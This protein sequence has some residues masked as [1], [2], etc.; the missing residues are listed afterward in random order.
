MSIEAMLQELAERIEEDEDDDECRDED[1]E[2]VLR[3]KR[4][5]VSLK[6]RIAALEQAARAVLNGR[7]PAVSAEFEGS[8][9]RHSRVSDSL[10]DKLAH[11]LDGG[12]ADSVSEFEDA[13]D[14]EAGSKFRAAERKEASCV[15]VGFSQSSASSSPSSSSARIPSP[16]GSTGA[17]GQQPSV[18]AIDSTLREAATNAYD[19]WTSGLTEELTT[20]MAALRDVLDGARA[21][22]PIDDGEAQ[23]SVRTPDAAHWKPAPAGSPEAGTIPGVERAATCLHLDRKCPSWKAC[24]ERTAKHSA[25]RV[26]DAVEQCAAASV[27]GAELVALRKAAMALVDSKQIRLTIQS[28]SS[29]GMESAAGRKELADFEA[30]LDAIRKCSSTPTGSEG[31]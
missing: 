7:V 15:Q 30:L 12:R 16:T 14:S 17:T 21:T 29:W 9:W 5:Y 25:W 3:A 13:Y 2:R 18:S 23:A 1:V 31:A 11:V 22:K 20:A 26:T 8:D 27:V 24:A 6:G 4:Q 19:A 10:L 28:L